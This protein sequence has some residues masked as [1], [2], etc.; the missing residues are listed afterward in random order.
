MIRIGEIH[1]ED[2]VSQHGCVGDRNCNGCSSY[3][4]PDVGLHAHQLSRRKPAFH[5]RSDFRENTAVILWPEVERRTKWHDCTAGQPS[6][7]KTAVRTGS[8]NTCFNSRTDC[9]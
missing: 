3:I 4:G 5:V 8:L 9:C 1:E 7:A 2:F 6:A